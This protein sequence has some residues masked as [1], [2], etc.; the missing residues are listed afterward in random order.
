MKLKETPIQAELLYALINIG[1]QKHSSYVQ[2][3]LRG[4][5]AFQLNFVLGRQLMVFIENKMLNKIR[6]T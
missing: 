5:L 4:N 6:S 1:L 3:A 2:D